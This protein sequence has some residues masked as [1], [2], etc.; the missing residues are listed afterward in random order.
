MYIPEYTVQYI[1]SL[2]GVHCM[3]YNVQCILYICIQRSMY[4]V[5]CTL[6]T[7]ICI[8]FNITLD[9]YIESENFVEAVVVVVV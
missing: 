5:Q 1:M 2:Y 6:Y 9:I 3:L 8:M 4:T 7:A